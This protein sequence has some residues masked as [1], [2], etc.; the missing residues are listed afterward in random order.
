MKQNES[1][2]ILSA[3][4]VVG[5]QKVHGAAVAEFLDVEKPRPNIQGVAVGVKWRKGEPTGEPALLVLVSQKVD[6]DQLTAADLIPPKVQDMQTDVL[7]V[8]YLFAGGCE[9]VGA[10]IETLAR[11]VRPAKGGYSVG[12]Y[13]SRPAPSPPAS[14]TFSPAAPSAR[15]PTGSAYRP[16]T[17]S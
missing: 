1:R 9:P 3:K 15:P 7:A 8:G 13:K 10:G 14:T 2:M 5:V 4:D 11:R 17:T 16:G 12:H 6:K